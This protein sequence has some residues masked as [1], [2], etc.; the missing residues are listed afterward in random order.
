M[1][2][3]N[4]KTCNIHYNLDMSGEVEINNNMDLD[5][6]LYKT[7]KIS[8][9]DLMNFI[10]KIE[11]QSIISPGVLTPSGT[12]KVLMTDQQKLLVQFKDY[13]VSLELPK[14]IDT[15]KEIGFVITYPPPKLFKDIQ[16]FLKSVAI[17][18]IEVTT[19]G[20]ENIV[21]V[22]LFLDL[23]RM[24]SVSMA[25]TDSRLNVDINKPGE[26]PLFRG[27]VESLDEFKLIWSRIL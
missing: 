8:G 1:H 14:L 3:F 16:E 19:L 12:Y 18:D 9:E 22:S 13:R 21:S 23:D 5:Q 17:R 15:L 20:G 7:I 26:S 2:S 6:P 11:E 4:G 27:H 25:T 24:Y 10:H